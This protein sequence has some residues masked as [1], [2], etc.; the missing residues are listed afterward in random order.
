MLRHPPLLMSLSPSVFVPFYF[1]WFYFPFYVS[2]CFCLL[3]FLSAAASY[4]AIYQH[5]IRQFVSILFGNLLVFCSVICQRFVRQFG[6]AYM[7]HLSKSLFPFFIFPQNLEEGVETGLLYL[8]R[9][10]MLDERRVLVGL[11]AHERVERRGH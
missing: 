3:L 6:A 4:S 7:R 10:E 5:F 9:V 8:G 11:A 1:V 2:F